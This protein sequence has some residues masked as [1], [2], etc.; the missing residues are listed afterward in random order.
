MRTNYRGL[1]M[2]ISINCVFNEYQ[3]NGFLR[4]EYK[5]MAYELR[6]F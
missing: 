6:A 5:V 1:E 4:G 2:T 3:I